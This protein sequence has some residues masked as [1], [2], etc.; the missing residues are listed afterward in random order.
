MGI[1]SEATAVTPT[2][3]GEFGVTLDAQ[4]AVADKLHGGYLL[5]VVA[6]AAGEVAQHPH[7]TAISGSFPAAPVGGPATVRVEVLN[8]GGSQTQ[9]RADLV[10][11][12]KVRVAALVTQ[13]VLTADDPWWTSVEPITL[14]DEH[15]CVRVPAEV[16]GGGFR[17]PLMEV[18]ETRMEPA[19]AGFA[20]GRPTNRGVT[21]GYHRLADG[22]DWDPVSLLVALDPVPPVTFDLGLAGWVPTLQMTAYIRRLPAPGPVKVH[23]HANDLTGNRLDETAMAWDSKG[24]LVAQAIQFAGVRV[25][26]SAGGG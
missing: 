14:P 9:L 23:M 2:G 12:G 5:A 1:F 16:P 21:A 13:G 26:S 22:S 8:V 17:I 20:V 3:P 7:L 4:W 10:Q 11:D 19:S 15:E 6:R 24:R 18:E 25:P